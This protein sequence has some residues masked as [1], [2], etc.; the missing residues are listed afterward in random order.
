MVACCESD[1]VQFLATVRGDFVEKGAQVW[2]E[3]LGVGEVDC[4]AGDYGWGE[5]GVEG[6]KQGDLFVNFG[7]LGAYE[8]T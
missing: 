3:G 8:R 2:L 5:G 4:V 6:A 7:L 1:V